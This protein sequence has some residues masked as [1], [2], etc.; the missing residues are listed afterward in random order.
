MFWVFVHIGFYIPTS[1]S[2]QSA[3]NAA[4]Y[5]DGITLPESENRSEL[6]QSRL[7]I[8]FVVDKRGKIEV[9]GKALPSKNTNDFLKRFLLEQPRGI[10]LLIIDKDTPMKFV[11]PLLQKLRQSGYSKIIFSTSNESQSGT[12]T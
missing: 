2:D 10:A 1:M 5:V 12:G 11:T 6:I 3:L 9:N 8:Y 4:V 7:A